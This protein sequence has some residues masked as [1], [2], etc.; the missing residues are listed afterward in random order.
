MADLTP[1]RGPGVDDELLADA[2]AAV[3]TAWVEAHDRAESEDT[4][5]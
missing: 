4:N 3:A 5:G 2:A 1:A